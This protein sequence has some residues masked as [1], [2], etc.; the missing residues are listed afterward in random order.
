MLKDESILGLGCSRV[1]V[2]KGYDILGLGVSGLGCLRV[3][4]FKC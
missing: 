1:R 2:F 4:V 3:R